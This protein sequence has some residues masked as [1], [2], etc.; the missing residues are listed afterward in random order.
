VS[1]IDYK[2]YL[3][4][5]VAV[6]ASNKKISSKSTSSEL[7]ILSERKKSKNRL[8]TKCFAPYQWLASI[9]SLSIYFIAKVLALLSSEDINNH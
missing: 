4:K 9:V 6:Y 5:L 7:K 1:K 3:K 8:V 2:F